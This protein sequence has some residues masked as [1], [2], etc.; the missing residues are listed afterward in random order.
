MTGTKS[1]S[2]EEIRTESV[3]LERIPVD[4]V[5]AHLK[6]T[7]EGLSSEEGDERLQI[8]G[9]NKLEEKKVT[10]CSVQIVLLCVQLFDLVSAVIRD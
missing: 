7:K 8:F 9:S 1:I 4:E 5:F 2:L 6:C 10:L 3:D